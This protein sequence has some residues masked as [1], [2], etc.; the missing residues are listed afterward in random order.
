MSHA[1]ELSAE[2]FENDSMFVCF[3]QC[4]FIGKEGSEETIM[5]FKQNLTNTINGK[6]A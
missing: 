5:K 3:L 4:L 6:A 1:G 2:W